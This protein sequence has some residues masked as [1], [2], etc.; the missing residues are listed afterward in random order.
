MKADLSVLLYKI[1]PI[2]KEKSKTAANMI[3]LWFCRD[4]KQWCM[5]SFQMTI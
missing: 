5:S 1:V 4:R 2:I 3:K